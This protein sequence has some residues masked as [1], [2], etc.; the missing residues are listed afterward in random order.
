M[1]TKLSC[2][3]VSKTILWALSI[4]LCSASTYPVTINSAAQSNLKKSDRWLPK[5]NNR[6]HFV[7]TPPTLN[8][9]ETKW[10][11]SEDGKYALSEGSNIILWDVALATPLIVYPGSAST[12][13]F[14]QYAP[15]LVYLKE[16]DDQ[17]SLRDLY[18]AEI[19]GFYQSEELPRSNS[20]NLPESFLKKVYDKDTFIDFSDMDIDN[21]GKNIIAAGPIPLLWDLSKA[22]P[23]ILA[24]RSHKDWFASLRSDKVAYNSPRYMNS[25]DF[26]PYCNIRC[27]FATDSLVYF[28]IPFDGLHLFDID[29]KYLKH[30]KS[31]DEITQLRKFKDY[32]ILE[33]EHAVPT[34]MHFSEKSWRPIISRNGVTIPISI[35][36]DISD[37]GYFIGIHPGS[38]SKFTIGQLREDGTARWGQLETIAG[39]SGSRIKRLCL[40]KSARRFSILRDYENYIMLHKLDIEKDKLSYTSV[41]P[42]FNDFKRGMSAYSGTF[43]GDST[44]VAGTLFGEAFIGRADKFE[45]LNESAITD[46]LLNHE[47]SVV[48]IK[49]LDD[50]RFATVDSYGTVRIFDST[51]YELI[52][53]MMYF[54]GNNDYII[55]TPDNYY[56]T[57]KGAVDKLHYVQGLNSFTFKQFDLKYNRPDIIHERLGGSPDQ[58]RILRSAWEKRLKKMGFTQSTV[59]SA[60]SHAPE[61]TILNRSQIS[62]ST[63]NGKAI[64]ELTAK[65]QEVTIQSIHVSINDVPVYGSEGRKT[66]ASNNLSETIELPLAEGLNNI[67]VYCLNS[68]GQASLHHQIAVTNTRSSKGKTLYIAAVGV[69]EYKD[70]SRNLQYAASDATSFASAIADGNK[71]YDEVK[72]LTIENEEFSGDALE[73]LRSFFN[74]SNRDDVVILYYAGHGILDKSLDYYLGCTDTDFSHPEKNAV[75]YEDFQDVLEG[76]PS[77]HRYCF[78][79]ACHSG[80]I[81]KDD[82]LAVN[83]IP[84]EEYGELKFRTGGRQ[85]IS[86][87]NREIARQYHSMFV[88]LSQKSGIT[89]VASSNGDELSMESAAYG[90]G[91]F[92]ASLKNALKG[93]CDS[94]N[95]GKITSSEL[96]EYV[97]HNVSEASGG[98]QNPQ[99][100]FHDN[101]KNI[102]L[103]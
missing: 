42:T 9:E 64:I 95:D 74:Q 19:K 61:L 62:G 30:I 66:K 67:S 45:V 49:P 71:K 20:S 31:G 43:I 90:G 34:I 24:T 33:R 46:P 29:G 70:T 80:E 85:I 57:S 1:K 101:D 23:K 51:N 60:E 93:K 13:R 40:S 44:F 99:V 8:E 12:V 18:T 77:L 4:S 92:T 79:D 37:E 100:K 35:L 81:D 91:L 14:S 58:I 10:T 76:I 96:L 56:K 59:V 11:L 28:S 72:I 84:I 65:D 82:Y 86:T 3:S 22:E 68:N 78:V 88:D 38:D 97:R 47:G 102:V 103:K 36:S 55:Y 41:L 54:P 83:S 73:K 52:M 7:V 48:G 53:T 39:M 32:I 27:V 21:S 25:N 69:S 75:R 16:K 26:S 15:H 2:L 63:A 50:H 98:R 17:W 87:V 89:V 5:P 94:N 6:L